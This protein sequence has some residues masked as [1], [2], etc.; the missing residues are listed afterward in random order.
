MADKSKLW[1]QSPVDVLRA[2]ASPR[3]EDIDFTATPG[4]DGKKA[5]GN[6]VLEER[7]A[8]LA[9]L[10]EKL[11]AHGRTGD[12]RSVLLVLQGMD[13]A[14]KGGMV[15]HVIGMVDPQGVDLA[16]FGVPTQQEK[17]HHYLWRIRKALPRAGRIGVFDRSHYEDVLVVAVHDLVPR[18]VWEQRFDEINA[19][20]KELTDEGTIVVKVAL[21]VSADEQK[22]RL[23]ERLDRPDKYWKYNP[24][25]VTERGFLPQYRTAYQRVLDRTDTDHAPWY[26]VPADRKWYSRLAVTE[27]LI[28]AL[29][30]LDLDWPAPDFDVELE[31]KRL[32][33]S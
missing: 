29:E 18:E 28:D 9:A 17:Q 32:A 1:T 31:K 19:F 14:G 10:Q 8:V 24:G 12:S 20:E 27:I 6:D 25:D 23:Q 16:S 22:K 30:Q 3:V 15:K 4:F 5:H 11:Y 13:T 33:E 26:V 2:S 21:F 7:G